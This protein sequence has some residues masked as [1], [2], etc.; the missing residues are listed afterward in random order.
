MQI[1][2]F[3][4]LLG[5]SGHLDNWCCFQ[6]FL[7]WVILW[8]WLFLCRKVRVSLFFAKRGQNSTM[9]I[10]YGLMGKL[11]TSRAWYGQISCTQWTKW[12]NYM[13]HNIFDMNLIL[14]IYLVS[15]ASIHH[16]NLCF[17]IK[18]LEYIIVLLNYGDTSCKEYLL[19]NV[20]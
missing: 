13:L 4:K 1:C 8:A 7:E 9:L 10:M 17:K 15:I 20:L 5:I 3:R 12:L 14:Y 18:L 11:S 2:R 6:S 19:K 16:T